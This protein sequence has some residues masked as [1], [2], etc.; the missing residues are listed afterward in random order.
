MTKPAT[1]GEATIQAET[2][3][4]L[5]LY[6]AYDAACA[7]GGVNVSDLLWL[8]HKEGDRERDNIRQRTNYHQPPLGYR[9]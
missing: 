9:R 8:L 7:A 4:V 6:K 5:K 3:A 1:I 2:E